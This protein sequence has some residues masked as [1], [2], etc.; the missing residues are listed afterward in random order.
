MTD[1]KILMPY[2]FTPPDQKALDF[3]IRSYAGN[4]NVKITLFHTYSPL[5]EVD[6]KANPEIQKMMR[7][8]NYLATELREKEK[9]LNSAKAYLVEKGFQEDAVDYVFT[10]KIKSSADEII[11]TVYEH[12]Y[13]VLVISRKPGKMTQLFSRSVHNKVLAALKDVVVCIAT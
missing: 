8:I 9:G 11:Q 12:G 13:D 5:P 3:I 2:N 10:K 1:F 7:G 4:P 6:V